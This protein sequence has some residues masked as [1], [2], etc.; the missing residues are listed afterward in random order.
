MEII[1]D[2]QDFCPRWLREGAGARHNGLTLKQTLAADRPLGAMD[3]VVAG[4]TGA[5]PAA[6][7]N[8]RVT[9]HNFALS[10]SSPSTAR[11]T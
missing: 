7:R 1:T 3:Y 8:P 10:R 5:N 9:A 2:D 4:R 11:T 6:R